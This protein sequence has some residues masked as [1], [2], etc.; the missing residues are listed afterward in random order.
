MR[1]RLAGAQPSIR[2]CAQ[3]NAGSLVV[4]LAG[5]WIQAPRERKL[6]RTADL[7]EPFDCLDRGVAGSR[8]APHLASRCKI[9]QL[10]E[11]AFEQCVEFIAHHVNLM[12]SFLQ[13]EQRGKFMRTEHRVLHDDRTAL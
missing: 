10:N 3:A 5:D 8:Q 2:R 11:L 9:F 4:P 6:T 12:G 13:Q 1:K 7:R